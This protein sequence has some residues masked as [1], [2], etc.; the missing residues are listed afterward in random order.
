MRG[1]RMV[2]LV[3]TMLGAQSVF[4]TQMLNGTR[5]GTV[6]LVPSS[7]QY[8][9]A[10]KGTWPEDWY[11]F[12]NKLYWEGKGTWSL[13]PT[14]FTPHSSGPDWVAFTSA[15]HPVLF[16]FQGEEFSAGPLRGTG[17]AGFGQPKGQ[18]VNL[19]APLTVAPKPLV[20]NSDFRSDQLAFRLNGVRYAFACQISKDNIASVSL[21]QGDTKQLLYQGRDTGWTSIW[22]G[23]LDRDDRLDFIDDLTM[24]D[25]GC[26][27]VWLSSKAKPGTLVEKAAAT[28]EDCD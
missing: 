9:L 16:F 14:K 5:E 20:C 3:L 27:R 10:K 8:S 15:L 12:Y 23:D 22:V 18:T 4:A 2:M 7:S 26:S 1:Y 13:A 19:D 25:R 17:F 24:E 6:N 28:R 11:A 21:S